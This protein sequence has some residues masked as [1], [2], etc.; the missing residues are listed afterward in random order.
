MVLKEQGAE[1][2]PNFNEFIQARPKNKPKKGKGICYF[3]NWVCDLR[4]KIKKRDGTRTRRV[5]DRW[6]KKWAMGSKKLIYMWEKYS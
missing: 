3:V 1:P 2:D 5:V 6:E 4:G